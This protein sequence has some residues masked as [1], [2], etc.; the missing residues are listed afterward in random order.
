MLSGTSILTSSVT[1]IFSQPTIIPISN[2]YSASIFPSSSSGTSVVSIDIIPSSSSLQHSSILLV[3]SISIP[4]PSTPIDYNITIT[5]PSSVYLMHLVSLSSYLYPVPIF[6][7]VTRWFL[8]DNVYNDSQNISFYA[9][10][11]PVLEFTCEA[12]NGSY[13]S[14][15]LLARAEFVVRIG[16]ISSLVLITT[17][18]QNRTNFLLTE[19]TCVTNQ[20]VDGYVT[21]TWSYIDNNNN[22]Q[23]LIDGTSYLQIVDNTLTITATDP[24]RSGMYVCSATL[25]GMDSTKKSGSTTVQI[26]S[27]AQ[28]SLEQ[29]EGDVFNLLENSLFKITCNITG[30]ETPR[31]HWLVNGIAP[32]YTTVT[33]ITDITEPGESIIRTIFPRLALSPFSSHNL[34]RLLLV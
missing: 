10:S 18:E 3:S 25:N 28:V 21:Y 23:E 22:Q 7:V 9:P 17:A 16:Y 11:I 20:T 2:I 29:P 8:D 15:S 6:P 19:I 5:G 14:A 4:D 26:Y 31:I 13:D 27:P 33:L 32:N 24:A 34:E 1:D 12:F 30:L